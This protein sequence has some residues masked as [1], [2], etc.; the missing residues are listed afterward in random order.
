[1]R[2]VEDVEVQEIIVHKLTQHWFACNICGLKHEHRQ[3]DQSET[4]KVSMLQRCNVQASQNPLGYWPSAY[5]TQKVSMING[6]TVY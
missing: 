3:S 6:H 5:T 1:M 4:E 2:D